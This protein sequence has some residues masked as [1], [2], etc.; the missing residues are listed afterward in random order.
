MGTS[1]GLFAW[2]LSTASSERC[3]LSLD[4]P[5]LGDSWAHRTQLQDPSFYCG[6]TLVIATQLHEQALAPLAEFLFG[7]GIALLV[8]CRD[9]RRPLRHLIPVLPLACLNA[10]SAVVWPDWDEHGHRP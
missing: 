2:I 5:V 1:R 10:D 8:R 3:G 4:L 6:F 9:P 7:H